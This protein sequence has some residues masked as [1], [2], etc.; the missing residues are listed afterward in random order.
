MRKWNLHINPVWLFSCHPKYELKSKSGK[1]GRFLR[2][3][4]TF[5]F[6]EFDIN[7]FSY[8]DILTS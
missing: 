6:I 2:I 3:Q 7:L 1:I 4:W 5:N 8:V